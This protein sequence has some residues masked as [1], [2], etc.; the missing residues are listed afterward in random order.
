MSFAPLGL[1]GVGPVAAGA[2]AATTAGVSVQR[3]ALDMSTVLGWKRPAR[4][5]TSLRIHPSWLNSAGPG[6]AVWPV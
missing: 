4:A 1:A 5:A 3:R 2:W 6:Q